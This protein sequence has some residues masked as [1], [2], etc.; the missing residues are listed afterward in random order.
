M[1]NPNAFE[2]MKLMLDELGNPESNFRAFHIAG[3][4]G[5][6][7]TAVMI[8]SILEAAGYSVGLYSSPHLEN[9]CERVQFWM[10]GVHRMIGQE[11]F[12]ELMGVIRDVRRR[13]WG[14]ETSLFDVYTGA[15]YLYFDEVRPDY[16]VLETGLGGRLDMT[17]TLEHP[18]VSV[19][20][21]IGLDHTAEL[22]DTVY[23]IAREKAGIIKA[24]VPVV[25]QSPELAVKNVIRGIAEEKG[26][27]FIDA[28]ALVCKYADYEIRMRGKHQLMN[29]V[30]AAE[31]VIVS[32]AA[33]AEADI[34]RGLARA[35]LPGR[36][37]ILKS[38]GD[39]HGRAADWGNAAAEAAP[40]GLCR[41]P[42]WIVIDG[43]HNP[44]AIASL[45]E[46]FNEWAGENKIKRTRVIF[47]CMK[48]KNSPHMVQLFAENMRGCSFGAAA[49]DYDRAEDPGMLGKL[50]EA[51]GC[52]CIVYSSA[53][54]AFSEAIASDFDCVLVAGSIYIA[55]AMRGFYLDH[56]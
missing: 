35:V 53:E 43:G 26:C 33:A 5:K 42:K 10:G 41:G 14:D 49:V 23:K 22:G 9:E 52:S 15:A 27:R 13:V 54:E 46:T 38:P 37:E 16:V 25:S 34:R 4:N 21:H 40:A 51:R 50:F 7:S 48:D 45:T 20:T 39:L 31:A 12:E 3:T 47:G 32:G 19:I 11:H 28:S 8:A 18:L 29:A 30:T 24:G 44:D 55:G 6:G 36:F 56:R 2:R 17:N 1:P